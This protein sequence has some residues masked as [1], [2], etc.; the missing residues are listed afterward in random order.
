MF[1][2][3][4]SLKKAIEKA[5]EAAKE[6][7]DLIV[8]PELVIPGYPVG[9]TFGFVMGARKEDGRED[10]KRYYENSI[11]IPGE[12]TEELSKCAKR[13]KSY[14]SIGVSERD[15]LTGTLFNS[16]LIFSPEGEI[17]SH[18]RKL[19]PTGTE[20]CVWGDA[21]KHY[22]P[23]ADSP[24]GNMGAAI[25]WEA[26]MPLLRVALYEKG[27]TIFISCNTNDNPEW[28]ATTQ[29]IALEGRCFFINADLFIRKE[30]Y[31][32]DL[33]TY[34]EVEKLSDITCRGGSSVVDPKGHIIAGPVWD[35]EEIIYADLDMSMVYANKMEFDPVGHYARPD[36]FK[37]E[38]EDK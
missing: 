27:I 22:F 18:H 8:F 23:V 1:D 10:W 7:A 33:K 36:V 13:T 9:M 14:I 20:R 16:N 11:L 31:P 34:S 3:K 21:N 15:S 5:E 28:Q 24:W 12:E 2:K 38:F 26:Y 19:K 30:A 32:K 35:K 29:H 37:F 6:G 25:C 4:A 17:V